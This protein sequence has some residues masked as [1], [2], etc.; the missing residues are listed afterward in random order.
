M[1]VS[2]Y[3]TPRRALPALLL[4]LLLA[5]LATLAVLGVPAPS[6]GADVLA[7]TLT[8]QPGVACET[9]DVIADNWP[10]GEVTV[11]LTQGEATVAWVLEVGPDV[12]G[13]DVSSFGVPVAAGGHWTGAASD[14]E[15][16]ASA[17]VDVEPCPPPPTE[18][19]TTTTTV[20]EET[21]TTTSSTTTPTTVPGEASTSTSTSTIPAGPGPAAPTTTTQPAAPTTTTTGTLG[22]LP[23]TGLP[24][25][26]LGL[27][28][29]LAAATGGFALWQW[30]RSP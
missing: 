11:T 2:P 22:V 29:L 20:A 15:A 24:L 1:T 27:A 4:A 26:P 6:A 5:L 28:G 12:G 17:A 21:T 14:G 16:Q 30:R 10:A 9:V 3:D 19:S 25:W 23:F 7:P 13:S 18:I 8:L